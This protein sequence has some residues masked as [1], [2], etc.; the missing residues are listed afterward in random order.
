MA[1]SAIFLVFFSVKNIPSDSGDT[2][3]DLHGLLVPFLQHTFYSPSF[4]S[5]TLVL[6]ISVPYS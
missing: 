6:G 2:S 1:I 5:G 3:A 4:R